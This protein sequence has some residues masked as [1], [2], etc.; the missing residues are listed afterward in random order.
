MGIAGVSGSG[1]AGCVSFV[2]AVGRRR[3]KVKL[4]RDFALY[5]SSM[6]STSATGFDIREQSGATNNLD[7]QLLRR[8]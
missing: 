2:A 3:P 1:L 5:V 4:D 6:S 8:G 7:R